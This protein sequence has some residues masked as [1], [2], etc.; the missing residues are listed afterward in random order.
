M[1]ILCLY[2]AKQTQY[3]RRLANSFDRIKH[4]VVYRACIEWPHN[5]LV[6]SILLWWQR[7]DDRSDFD[8]AF[9]VLFSYAYMYNVLILYIVQHVLWTVSCEPLRHYD[10]LKGSMFNVNIFLCCLIIYSICFSFI[11]KQRV[12]SAMIL[13]QN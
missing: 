5:T 13:Y 4:M 10:I 11:T 1:I 12:R 9:E 8:V 7:I 6:S 2:H 3:A